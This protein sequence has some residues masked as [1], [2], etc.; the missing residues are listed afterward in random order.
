MSE[1]TMEDMDVDATMAENVKDGE[2]KKRGR[3]FY[4]RKVCRFFETF[5]H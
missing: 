5:Y 4:K 3:V 2:E 1:E